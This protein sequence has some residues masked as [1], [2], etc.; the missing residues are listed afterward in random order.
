MAHANPRLRPGLSSAVPAGLDTSIES[1][2]VKDTENALDTY[3][4]H[5]SLWA[6]TSWLGNTRTRLALKRCPEKRPDL[7]RVCSG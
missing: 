4:A 2:S 1:V 6:D 5:H 7:L 3:G